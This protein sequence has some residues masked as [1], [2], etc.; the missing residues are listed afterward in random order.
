MYFA[1]F[2][3][4]TFLDKILLRG[5]CGTGEKIEVGHSI[6]MKSYAHLHWEKEDLQTGAPEQSPLS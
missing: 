4:T 2:G 1:L 5:W 3:K 6:V